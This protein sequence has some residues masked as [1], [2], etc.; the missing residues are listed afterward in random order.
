MIDRLDAIQARRLLTRQWGLVSTGKLDDRLIL[1]ITNDFMAESAA[2]KRFRVIIHLPRP[3]RDLSEAARGLSRADRL[4]RL[5]MLSN[6]SQAPVLEN[7]LNLTT[8]EGP[9]H[10]SERLAGAASAAEASLTIDEAIKGAEHIHG[11]IPLANAIVANLTAE[12]IQAIAARNDVESVEMD[13]PALPEL[14]V[15]ALAIGAKAV[16]NTYGLD[17][18]GI[19]VAVI[20]GE[21]D[22]NHPDL[23]G[24]VV[25]KR[26][27]DEPFGTPNNHETLVAGIIAGDGGMSHGT[28]V[29][30]APAATIWSYKTTLSLNVSGADKAQA[31][32]DAAADGSHIIN[33]SW[34]VE[35]TPRNG[36][37]L[38]CKAVDTAVQLG[39]VVVK[40]CGNQGAGGNGVGTTTCPANAHDVISVGAT[41]ERGDRMALS[42]GFDFSSRGPTADGRSKPELVAPGEDINGPEAGGGYT[43]DLY[44]D[45]TSFSA[46]HVAGVAALLLQA[47]PQLTPE[48]VREALQAS[49]K[50][51]RV[52]GVDLPENTQGAGFLSADRAID[53]LKTR[54]SVDLPVD[55]PQHP[56]G[57]PVIV[58]CRS[59]LSRHDSPPIFA[60]HLGSQR[61]YAVEVA[62]EP[63]LFELEVEHP[64]R[65]YFQAAG[66]IQPNFYAS[67]SD[68]P[69]LLRSESA[70]TAF[71]LSQQVWNVFRGNRNLYFR[72][73]TSELPDRWINPRFSSPDPK[74][75]PTGFFEIPYTGVT[76][77]SQPYAV[78]VN[79]V[80]R[81]YVFTGDNRYFAIEVA[82]EA[83]LFNL[84]WGHPQKRIYPNIPGTTPNFY[85]TWSDAPPLLQKQSDPTIYEAP[86]NIWNILGEPPFIY[87]RIITSSSSEGWLNFH[88]S[89]DNGRF[90]MSPS[91]AHPWGS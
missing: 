19:I 16:R 21:V 53:Y 40:S 54:F 34:R 28:Y 11:R 52:G 30:I 39:A 90:S 69:P 3:E 81:F 13:K 44:G 56:D 10:L 23:A 6:K 24:R 50:K 64:D 42:L 7:I 37:C 62:T 60:I 48:Q 78:S 43:S 46:P 4:A 31:I 5:L 45:G 20:G 32:L 89:V 72:L 17:G 70:D 85:A 38:W 26:T 8:R 2:L 29:G 88:Y 91:V 25:H 51:L 63:R 80:P 47:Q 49:T 61:Y 73:V 66:T 14:N 36:S 27:Y 59:W 71:Q 41:D 12:E 74:I 22:A 79:S 68:A 33:C 83:F 76:L 9:K 82:T 35:E 15:S 18:K 55:G 84:P 86:L 58:A 67:W 77:R 75:P 87:Y 57:P 65:I 1:N